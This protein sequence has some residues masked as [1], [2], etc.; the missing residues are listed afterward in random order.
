VLDALARYDAALDL[1]IARVLAV[2]DAASLRA[3]AAAAAP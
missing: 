1:P 2:S 3:V